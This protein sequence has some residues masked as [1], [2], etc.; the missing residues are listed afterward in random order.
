[1]SK[2]YIIVPEV[3]K[4]DTLIEKRDMITIARG[5]REKIKELA[6]KLNGGSG[7]RGLTPTFVVRPP[8]DYTET[9]KG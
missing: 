2:N 7:F 6:K 4:I 9:K 5:S 8:L 3:D 1:M